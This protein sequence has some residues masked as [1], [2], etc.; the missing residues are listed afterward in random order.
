ME[1]G[2]GVAGAAA[3]GRAVVEVVRVHRPLRCGAA[4]GN[5][6]KYSQKTKSK[7]EKFLN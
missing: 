6:A 5:E 2:R 1:R 7:I 4:V 3:D